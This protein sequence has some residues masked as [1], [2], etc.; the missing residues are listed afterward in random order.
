MSPWTTCSKSCGTGETTKRFKT[1]KEERSVNLQTGKAGTHYGKQLGFKWDAG[2]T[3]VTH[4]KCELNGIKAHAVHDFCNTSPCPVDCDQTKYARVHGTLAQGFDNGKYGVKENGKWVEKLN[5]E[6][7]TCNCGNSKTFNCWHANWKSAKELERCLLE[8]WHMYENGFGV[9]TPCGT[10]IKTDISKVKPG[11]PR[12]GGR[13][14]LATKKVKQCDCGR[15]CQQIDP[16]VSMKITVCTTNQFSAAALT[17]LVSKDMAIWNVKHSGH[18]FHASN[19]DANSPTG[20]CVNS[21]SGSKCKS[22]CLACKKK[23]TVFFTAPPGAFAKDVCA[24]HR[25][26]GKLPGVVSSCFDGFKC[27]TLAPTMSPTPV[28]TPRPHTV[29]ILNVIGGNYLSLEADKSKVYRDAGATCQDELDGPLRY[30]TTG[31]TVHYGRP[32]V[33][34]IKYNCKNFAGVPAK[35]AT[36]TVKVKATHCPTCKMAKGITTIEASFPYVDPGATCLES[37]EYEFPA[38]LRVKQVSDVNVEATGTYHVTY[39]TRDSYGNKNDVT[40]KNSKPYTRKIVVVDT[41]RPVVSLKYRGVKIQQSAAHFK[42]Q[43]GGVNAEANPAYDW[44]FSAGRMRAGSLMAEASSQN[45]W[46]LRHAAMGVGLLG[47]ALLGVALSKNSAKP[48]EAQVQV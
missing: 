37:S 23:T 48:S 4:I 34:K 41:L 26:A 40:C 19:L 13:E 43:L 1:V 35:E 45:A 11:T 16:P 20:P 17:A 32:A 31:D 47:I 5:P 38:K 8:P 9:A 33:Y 28:P 30:K 39:F 24:L 21:K 10:G 18:A 22:V 46:T 44:K 6:A 12:N 27:Q 3:H 2:K 36:R 29:P 15:K 14:C 25:Q 42:K 7:E